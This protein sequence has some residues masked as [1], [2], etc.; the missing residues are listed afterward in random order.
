M[1]RKV[2]YADH[3]ATTQLAP[4]ALEAMLPFLR[5]EYG[6]PSSLYSFSRLPQM[7]VK[8]ARQTI[9]L[10]INAKEN[11]IFFT[12]G[13]SESNNWVL[14]GLAFEP[15]RKD[16]RKHIITS[17][18][19]HHSVLNAVNDLKRLG[20]DVTMLP[21]NKFGEI[22]EEVFCNAICPETICISI[23][24]AN[25]E[26]GTIQNIPA[27]ARIARRYRVPF[28][29]DAVQVAGHL[30]LD[31]KKLKVDF[32]S[33]SAHKFN[34]PKGIGFL[35]IRKGMK[36]S[37][38]IS[39]GDQEQGRRAGTENVAAIL[40]MAEALK[41]HSIHMHENVKHISQLSTRFRN[42]LQR[43]IPFAQFNGSPDHCLP[44]IVSVSFPGLNGEA[45]MHLL[46]LK[47]GVIVSTGSACN[48]Q[49]KQPSHVLKAIKLSTKNAKGTIRV[50][51][52]H[53][54][55]VSDVNAVVRA[56]AFAV[57]ASLR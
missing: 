18:I 12:S 28:H 31:V 23:M 19:E 5:S 9:A 20:F 48:S 29:T 42:E 37:N 55:T 54:N 16:E 15:H 39:G 25:N 41:I 3:A 56:I 13:G 33:A 50:S 4:K 57:N 44:G 1:K 43:T 34:G 6:N 49:K 47:S 22:E 14:K 40:G 38:L 45:L 10:A 27:L 21:V 46:D 11:E 24:Y 32:M 17:A 53:E 2:I 8:T 51:F 52:A 30:P 35:Y 26:I 7:A 36:L